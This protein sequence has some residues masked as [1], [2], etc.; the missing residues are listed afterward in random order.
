MSAECYWHSFTTIRKVLYIRFQFYIIL[1][2]SEIFMQWVDKYD[3]SSNFLTYIQEY[4]CNSSLKCHKIIT[5][6]HFITFVKRNSFN[7]ND[8]AVFNSYVNIFLN[9]L[10]LKIK[11]IFLCNSPTL[12]TMNHR[13]FGIKLTKFQ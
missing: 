3:N 12:W 7:S 10:N 6:I 2:I 9:H 13:S 8:C 11:H 5:F 1:L 4:W